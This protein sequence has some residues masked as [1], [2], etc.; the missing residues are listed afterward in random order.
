ME[1]MVYK[2]GMDFRLNPLYSK[3]KL[4]FIIITRMTTIYVM[5]IIC[6]FGRPYSNGLQDPNWVGGNV[7]TGSNICQNSI[8]FANLESSTHAVTNHGQL[9]NN[10]LLTLLYH[11]IRVLVPLRIR[12]ATRFFDGI[13]K[14]LIAR[15]KKV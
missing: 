4:S 8:S 1:T 5:K 10:A 2:R 9:D 15:S 12:P 13:A 14:L 11:L 7:F 3:K 6:Q